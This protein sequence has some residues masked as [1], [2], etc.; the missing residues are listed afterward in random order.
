MKRL[1]A[2]LCACVTMAFAGCSNTSEDAP[3]TTTTAPTSQSDSF[4]REDNRT[5]RELFDKAKS[6]LG[7]IPMTV[8]L[9]EETFR[10][11]YG[12]G[13]IEEFICE[14]P[15]MN[16]HATEICV[17]KFKEKVSLDD[18]EKFFRKRQESLEQIWENYL[19]DQYEI[20]KNSQVGV[21]GRYALYCIGEK[22]EDAK[23]AF[24]D[25]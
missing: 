8:S 17:V 1:I 24:E 5:A 18:A 3:D 22:A 11:F 9:D 4:D 25:M 16:V 13:E 15:S 10:E 12:D 6:A 23:K 19:P 14:I 7:E 21:N 2:F 20:V